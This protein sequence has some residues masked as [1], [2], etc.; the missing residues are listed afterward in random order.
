MAMR[1]SSPCQYCE[2][3]KITDDY[4]CHSHCAEYNEYRAYCDIVSAHKIAAVKAIE[5]N[6]EAYLRRTKKRVKT[7]RGNKT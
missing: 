7:R 5:V 2:K 4:N 3:R 1:T 6:N